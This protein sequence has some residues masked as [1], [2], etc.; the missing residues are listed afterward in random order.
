M[1]AVF[2]VHAACI[3]GVEA[4]PITVEV[5][6]SQGLPGITI[7]GMADMSVRESRG[8]VRSALR[9]AGFDIPRR[10]I[11]VNLA[12]SDMRK[13]GSNLDLPIAVAILAVS[14]QIP[15]NGLDDCLFI[16]ELA[17]NGQISPVT[18]E[19]AYQLLARDEHLVLVGPAGG[20]HVPVTGIQHR[21]LP[22]LSRLALGI[23]RAVNDLPAYAAEMRSLPQLDFGDVVGQETA[24]RGIAIA[25]VGELGMLM[26]GAPGSGKTMLAQR[27]TSILPPLDPEEQQEAL[28]IHSV[29]GEPIDALLA[30]IRP[31]RNPHHSV[32]SAGLLGGG[33]P[34]RPGEISLAHGG[35]LFLDELGEFPPTVLQAL[36]Q[37]LEEGCVRIVR[38]EGMFC[39]PARFQLLGASNPCPC[40]YLGDHSIPCTCSASAIERYRAR[41]AGPLIDRIDIIVDVARPDPSLVIQGAE[42]LTTDELRQIVLCGREFR[43]W[44]RS[45]QVIHEGEPDGSNRLAAIKAANIDEG[46]ERVLL[47]LARRGNLTGRG[48]SRI[49]RIARTIADID[50]SERV[51]ESHVLEAGVFQGRR[52]A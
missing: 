2:A 44:R 25:A 10:S 30:G 28:R 34:V 48:V 40:G 31:Y 8:R 7:L 20:Q 17:L 19:V 33:R 45:R 5:S 36:R 41:L 42:G 26:I 21:C 47:G 16:G 13:S 49:C 14:G 46:A 3:R 12:P 27:M 32:S 15:L 50:E 37:P 24:K 11:V 6:M 23:E 1:G 52:P 4:V 39:F 22:D 38:V 35:V 29:I 9:S 51:T 43:D 18:G